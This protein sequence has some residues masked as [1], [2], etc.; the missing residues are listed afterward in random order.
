MG[1]AM[2]SARI[3]TRRGFIKTA[4]TLAALLPLVQL[5]GCAESD[6]EPPAAGNAAGTPAPGISRTPGATPSVPAA[7][8]PSA[9]RPLDE[10]DAMAEALGYRH[11]AADVDVERFP[12]YQP[13]HTCTSCSLYQAAAS[14]DAG[15]GGCSIFPGRLVDGRGWCN[16]YVAAA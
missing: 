13:G 8:S 4:G 15:W 7:Q 14:A 11:L 6:P 2:E 9:P 10:S 3:P 1:E 12:R 5:T 16:A